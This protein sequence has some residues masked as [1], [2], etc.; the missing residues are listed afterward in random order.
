MFRVLR[1]H[2]QDVK[3]VLYG[4]W[5]HHTETSEWSKITKIQFYIFSY[6]W[7]AIIF[8]FTELYF[9]NY[10]LLT[11]FSMMIPDAV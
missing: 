5:Y 3:I 10:R 1:A 9:S 6:L 2:H 11:C 8:I 4:L 7:N